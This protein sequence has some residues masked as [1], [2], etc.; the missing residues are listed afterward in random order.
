MPATS[1]PVVSKVIQAFPRP[2][3]PGRTVL[4]AVASASLAAGLAG[5]SAGGTHAVSAVAGAL[6]AVSASSSPSG[7]FASQPTPAPA[8][9][10][11]CGTGDLTI[12]PADRNQQ[13]GVDVARFVVQNSGASACVINGAM[14]ISPQGPL[15]A[16]G[17]DLVVSLAVSQDPFPDS[18]T[19]G[20][21]TAAAVP[22][23]R[24]QSAAFFIG[25]FPAS[26]VVCEESD[27]FTFSAPADDAA[28]GG[29]VSYPFG[30]MCNG[31][32]YVSPVEPS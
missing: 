11:D 8:P 14:Q 4:L 27:G 24:G 29:S 15:G 18:L 16:Q 22:L 23:Q 20:P 6:P 31:L 32:F 13:E 10:R 5:C 7:S 21:H 9:T 3:R 25:W 28:G 17:S 19:A 30:P 26:P 12:S 2:V 1:G